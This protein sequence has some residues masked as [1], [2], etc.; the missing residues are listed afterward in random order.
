M[1][2]FNFNDLPEKE[3][4]PGFKGKF[5]HGENVTYAYWDIEQ[6]AVLPLH[7]HVHEQLTNLITGEF[8]MTIGDETEVFKAGDVAV[9]PSNIP[10]E[11]VALTA[12]TIIDVFSPRRDDL[13]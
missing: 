2:S 6:G 13:M 5:V 1:N 4:M 8:K 3:I 12:C 9:I 11:G 10:H 7:R